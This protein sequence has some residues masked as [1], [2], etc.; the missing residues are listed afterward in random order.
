MYSKAFAVPRLALV[1]F[2]ILILG[3]SAS[4]QSSVTEE[5]AKSTISILDSTREQD[6]LSG[7]VRRVHTEMSRLLV[8]AGN[9]VEE[10]RMLLE[11]TTYDPQ[12]KRIWNVYYPVNTGSFKGNQEFTYDAQGHVTEMTLRDDTGRVLSREAYTYEFDRFGNWTKMS[13]SLVILEGDKLVYE[14]FEST[15]RAIS[16]YFDDSV[17]Q[18][19]KSTSSSSD[20]PTSATATDITKPN[21]SKE[22]ST[23]TRASIKQP[24]PIKSPG[25]GEGATKYPA[26]IEN[27]RSDDAKIEV[28][29]DDESTANKVVSVKASTEQAYQIPATPIENQLPPKPPTLFA[30]LSLAIR[31]PASR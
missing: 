9:V 31:I 4:A 2:A 8:D 13:S 15:F 21:P 23:D 24:D 27:A 29:R 18:I 12:G 30:K 1:S 6:G 3:A 14:P 7:P 25:E 20:K 19:I 26:P 28:P 5:A 22:A 11:V 16:Y 17:A 10:P